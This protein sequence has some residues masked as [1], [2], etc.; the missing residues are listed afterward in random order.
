MNP[1]LTT[2]SIG[3]EW[4]EIEDLIDEIKANQE[5]PQLLESNLD[6]QKKG[7]LLVIFHLN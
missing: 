1:S 3:P 4:K 7:L 2:T 5:D 6:K